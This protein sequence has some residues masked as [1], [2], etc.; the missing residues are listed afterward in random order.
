MSQFAYSLIAVQPG[1][2]L[3]FE[4]RAVEHETGDQTFEL[5]RYR[6]IAELASGSMHEYRITPD[7]DFILEWVVGAERIFGVSDDEL[8]ARG[9]DSFLVPEDLPALGQRMAAY[10][11]GERVEFTARIIRSDGELRWMRVANQPFLDPRTGQL[12]RMT[13]FSTDVTDQ[14]RAALALRDSEFRHRTVLELTPGFLCEGAIGSDGA[15]EFTWASPSAKEFF[16][17]GVEDFNRL[18]WRHFVPEAAVP[19]GLEQAERTFAGETVINEIPVR[20]HAGD[21][22]WLELKSSPLQSEPTRSK[23]HPQRRFIALAQDVTARR[24]NEELLRSQA[25]AFANMSEGVVLTTFHGVIRLTNPAFDAFFGVESGALIGNYLTELP[26]DPP[27]VLTTDELDHTVQHFDRAIRR[28]ARIAGP[29]G[30]THSLDITV[31]PL[32]LRGERFW[33]AVL[34][35]ITE[36]QSLEREVLEITNREQQR[37]GSDLHDGLGQELTGIALLLRSLANKAD[38]TIPAMAAPIEE[39]ARLVNDAIFT[40]RTLAR[41]LTP[42][43]FDRG[44]LANALSDLARRSQSTYNVNVRCA[45]DPTVHKMIG[46]SVAMHLYRMA[47]EAV[48]NAA[49]HAQANRIDISL[50][51][52]GSRGRLIVEDD[53][54]GVS[55]GGTGTLKSDSN[56]AG[57]GL[58]IMQYRASMMA[59]TLDINND[60]R[61]GTR[62]VCDF[63]LDAPVANGR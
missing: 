33:L 17:C 30:S 19:I 13:G 4:P 11:R 12:A 15:V 63:P 3:N 18:G 47:Q 56:G 7:G 1:T 21:L 20:N 45:A 59:G 61:G 38:Q 60:P 8:K 28:P 58:R 55:V 31:T 51:C 42:V 48:A 29:L 46:D 57:M 34:Q 37:I 2:Q 10:R 44:G 5:A 23:D 39:I 49:R 62:I 25:F 41:G 22:R 14:H 43:T 35:D 50:V 54:I 26:T 24:A 53:G 52:V 36:R 9:S 6:A 27:L 32:K 40:T 16:G